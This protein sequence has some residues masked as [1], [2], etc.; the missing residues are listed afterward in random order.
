MKRIFYVT[1]MGISICLTTST[2]WGDDGT[3]SGRMT[4]DETCKTESGDSTGGPSAGNTAV[5]PAKAPGYSVVSPVGRSAV[6][7]IKQELES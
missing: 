1:A 2:L 5:P 7:P 6:K 3:Q 4:C